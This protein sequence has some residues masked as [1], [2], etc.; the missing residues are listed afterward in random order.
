MGAYALRPPGDEFDAEVSQGS[1]FLRRLKC[2]RVL[3]SISS[4]NCVAL[5][6]H[7]PSSASK[8][9]PAVA[10]SNVCK[11]RIA[12]RAAKFVQVR[13]TGVASSQAGTR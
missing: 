11:V 1:L 5:K 7:R 10:D 3:R 2:A 6:A 12:M 4:K 8:A 9:F 13:R